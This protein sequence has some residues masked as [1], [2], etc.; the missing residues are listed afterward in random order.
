MNSHKNITILVIEDDESVRQTLQDMLELNG[1]T[2]LTATNGRD[3][4][5][6]ARRAVPALI[7]TDIE[8]PG[9][10]GFELLQRLRSDPDLRT[11]PVIV[12]SAKADRLAMRQG[13][14]LGA[15][16]FITKPFTEDE[17]IHSIAAR[18]EKKEL[19]DELDAFAH[20][21]AHDLKNPLATLNGRLHLTDVMLSTADETATRHQLAEA[22][23]AAHRLNDII[24]ELLILAGVR[25]QA[26]VPQALDMTACVSEALDRLEALLQEHAAVVSRPESW[27]V[28]FGHAPWVIEVWANFISNAAKYGGTNPQIT[29]G[30][31]PGSDGTSVRFWVQDHGLGL[32]T[33]TQE[34]MF[35]P[36]T[37]ISAVRAKGHGLGLSIVRRI[38][39]KLGGTVGVESQ[40][41]AGSRFWFELPTSGP[42]APPVDP[43]APPLLF[44]P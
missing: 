23:K 26:I 25:R 17:V 40:P 33:A 27:P 10:T 12:L 16:D 13:M 6:V 36:F 28:A 18:L 35:V 1:F 3:G 34:Q 11:L 2:V 24:N 19:L 20:T 29:I 15:S 39:E 4:Y 9:M 5:A 41:G 42:V 37:R 31:D 43:N 7:L 44:A 32:D 22:T 14:E 30:S 8:M 21:V 38:V